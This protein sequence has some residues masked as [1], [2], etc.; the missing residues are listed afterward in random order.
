MLHPIPLLATMDLETTYHR[1]R[2]YSHHWRSLQTKAVS[3]QEKLQAVLHERG[4]D[5]NPGCY[6]RGFGSLAEADP[7]V[8]LAEKYLRLKPA[9]IEHTRQARRGS[10]STCATV[11]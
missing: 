8:V 2:A 6:N 5:Q 3:G 11:T 7:T 4:K 10:L 1:A 9:M